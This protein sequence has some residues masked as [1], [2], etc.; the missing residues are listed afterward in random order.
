MDSKRRVESNAEGGRGFVDAVCFFIGSTEEVLEV[1]GESDLGGERDA[2]IEIDIEPG[3]G[4][5][6]RTVGGV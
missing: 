2:G 6:E 3:G 5:G 4:V 1:C